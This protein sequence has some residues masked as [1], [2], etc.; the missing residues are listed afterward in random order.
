MSR[1][2]G[3]GD[4]RGRS[5]DA[6]GY[7]DSCNDCEQAN[8]LT[9]DNQLDYWTS[10][11]SAEH[12]TIAPVPSSLRS[13]ATAWNTASAKVST[14]TAAKTSGRQTSA[15]NPASKSTSSRR[16]STHTVSSTS[17]A[18]TDTN[19]PSSAEGPEFP[20]SAFTITQVATPTAPLPSIQ[21]TQTPAST[22]G[23]GDSARLRADIYVSIIVVWL[24]GLWAL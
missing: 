19:A 9:A 23:T 1:C 7:H 12:L 21:N 6:Q 20:T 2:I 16:T 24:A 14:T 13:V 4:I 11:C 17:H 3:D 5:A 10:I 18:S 22:P 8:H 15:T